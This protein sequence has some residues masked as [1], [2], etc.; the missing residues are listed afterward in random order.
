M[1]RPAVI[2]AAAGLGTRLGAGLPKG[3]VDVGGTTIVERAVAGAQ[4][5]DVFD[6]VIVTAPQNYLDEFIE[7]CPSARVIPGGDTRQASVAAALQEAGDAEIIV[8]HDAA[9]CLTPPE[10][11][12]R[13]IAALEVADG[14]IATLPMTDTVKR[15]GPPPASARRV[16]VSGERYGSNEG[17]ESSES[18]EFVAETLDRATL[19]RVQTPQAFR[20]SALRAAH[21]AGFSGA[22][23]DASLIEAWGG[24]VVCVPGSPLARKITTPSDM[25]LARALL[26]E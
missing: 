2:V 18:Y 24:T 14:A 10:V 9:R 17:Q 21:A 4:S 23:D 26:E 6:Q 8:V 16:G 22:T 25:A 12:H 11:F 13:V 15:I 5:A 7:L 1:P 3:L 19:R 20:A